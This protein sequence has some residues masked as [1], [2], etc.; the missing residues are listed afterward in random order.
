MAAAAQPDAGAVRRRILRPAPEGMHV[1]WQVRLDVSI[2]LAI[3][4]RTYAKE[5]QEFFERAWTIGAP[6]IDFMLSTSSQTYRLDLRTMEQ[7]CTSCAEAVVTRRKVRRIFVDD[8]TDAEPSR[9]SGE[10]A[11]PSDAVGPLVSYSRFAH[12]YF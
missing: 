1:E 10:D 4:W 9:Q 2:D 11:A 5:F 3:T 12:A 7:M 6:H 8:E